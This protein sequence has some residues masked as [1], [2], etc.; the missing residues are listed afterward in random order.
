MITE[1]WVNCIISV[2]ETTNH[3]NIDAEKQLTINMT[4]MEEL[5]KTDVS[6][7]DYN[8]VPGIKASGYVHT[9]YQTDMPISKSVYNAN[10][11]HSQE[12]SKANKKPVVT[13]KYCGSNDCHK[14]YAQTLR[15]MLFGLQNPSLGKEWYC[16]NCGSYF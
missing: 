8:K 16:R 9:K 11:N 5:D 4:E 10:S 2:K 12:Q 13:C 7:I 14:P 6:S 3:V 1:L 15:T